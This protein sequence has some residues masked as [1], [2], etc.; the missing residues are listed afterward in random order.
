[1]RDWTKDGYTLAYVLRRHWRGVAL[2][3]FVLLVCPL[4]LWFSSER[5][6]AWVE[7]YQPFPDGEATVVLH[8]FCM[9]R[10][11]AYEEQEWQDFIQT[12][13]D[14]WNGAGSSFLFRTRLAQPSDDPCNL[15]GEV[16]VIS[17]DPD[18]LCPGDGP[19]KDVP[20]P[21]GRTEYRLGGARVYIKDRPIPGPLSR[22]DGIELTMV[23]ELGHVVGLTHPDEYGQNV[24]AVM[25]STNYYY[26]LQPDDIAG[27]QALYPPSY[28]EEVR[29]VL[30]IPASSDLP[31]MVSGIS[32]V[33]GW[34]CDADTVEVSIDGIRFT[35]VYGSERNDTKEVCGDTNNGFGLVMNWNLFR[36][37]LFH[38]ISVY[39][40]GVEFASAEFTVGSLGEEFF[41]GRDRVTY[42][43]PGFPRSGQKTTIVWSEAQQNFAVW[44][45][46]PE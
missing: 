14:E 18:T 25:N 46:E 36:A 22:A 20:G 41:K 32:M 38:H 26:S 40:D 23:H 6:D 9:G 35:A 11:C 45:V 34:V 44:K 10:T 33:S 28:E 7:G 1:M 21:V 42:H 37:A 16:V 24:E 4:I 30:E 12:A 27:I 31:T 8:R 15:P 13:I 19:L 17:V 29:G 2:V 5:A 39:A 3:V 43:L